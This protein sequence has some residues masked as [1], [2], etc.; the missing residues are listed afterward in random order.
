MR[1]LRYPEGKNSNDDTNKGT[2]NHDQLQTMVVHN[3]AFYFLKI[4]LLEND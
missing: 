3:H 2:S 1:P 4:P